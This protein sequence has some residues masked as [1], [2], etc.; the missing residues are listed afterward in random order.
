MMLLCVEDVQPDQPLFRLV[1][2]ALT[3]HSLMDID[4]LADTVS[5]SISQWLQSN[6]KNELFSSPQVN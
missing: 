5:S 2:P 3:H 1:N 6:T 4:K